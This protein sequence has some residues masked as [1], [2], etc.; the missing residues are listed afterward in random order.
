MAKIHATSISNA[1][2]RLWLIQEAATT[3]DVV[4]LKLKP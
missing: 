1:A 3:F 4:G 2:A